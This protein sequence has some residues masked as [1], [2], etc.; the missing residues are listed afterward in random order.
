MHVRAALSLTVPRSGSSFDRGGESGLDTPVQRR[1]AVRTKLRLYPA[2]LAIVALGVLVSGTGVANAHGG[3]KKTLRLVATELQFE[4]IDVGAP[5]TSVG[6]YF[7]LSESLARRGRDVGM[8]GVVC[9]IVHATPPYDVVTFQCVGT[10]SLRRG[11]ITLQGLLEFQGEDDPGPFTVAITGGTG[12]YRG[13]GGEAVVR[14][15]DDGVSVYRLRLDLP[16]K[17]HSRGHHKH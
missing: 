8:S 7:V 15:V 3:G 11:Q 5:G 9:T 16:K 2:V 6:D 4:F 13:A 10:F 1:Q 12:A 17:H 14:L